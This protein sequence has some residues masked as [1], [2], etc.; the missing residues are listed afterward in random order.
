MNGKLSIKILLLDDD[1]EKAVAFIALLKSTALQIKSC[2]LIT[3]NGKIEK[4]IKILGTNVIFL[5]ICQQ[6]EKSVSIIEKIRSYNNKIPIIILAPKNYQAVAMELLENGAHDYLTDNIKDRLLIE[7]CVT[8]SIKNSST[9]TALIQSNERYELVSKATNDMMWDWDLLN[10]KVFRSE[11]GWNKVFGKQTH[12]ESALVD[13]W[14][15]RTHPNDRAK[16]DELVERILK[17]KT[18]INFELENRMLRNDGMYATVMDRGYVVRNEAGEVIRLIGATQDITKQKKAEEELKKLSKI[19]SETINAVA[20]TNAAGIIQW[21]NESFST[22]TGYSR[23]EIEGVGFIDFFKQLCTTEQTLKYLRTRFNAHKAFAKDVLIQTKTKQKSWLRIQGQPQDNNNEKSFFA[24]M[25]DVSKEK[26]TEEILKASERRFRNMIEKSSEGL[27]LVNE[28]G[29]TLEISL[30]GKKILG[31]KNDED[32]DNSKENLIYKEDVE[33]VDRIFKEVIATPGSVKNAEYRYKMHNGEFIWLESAFHNLLHEPDIHA[34]AIHFRDITSRKYFEQVLRNSEEN[35]RNLFNSNP[36]AIFIWNPQDFSIIEVNEAAIKEY[37]FSKKEFVK[38]GMKAL[39]TKEGI[40][41]LQILGKRITAKQDYK[42]TL[43]LKQ[44]VKNGSIKL[45]EINFRTIDYYGKAACLAIANNITEKT[46][47]EQKL[48]VERRLRQNEITGAVITAQ[49]Q[50]REELGKELHDNINQILATTKLYIEHALKNENMRTVL[51]QSAKGFITSAV[52]EIRSL[53]KS[54]LPPSLGE[55]GLLM[56]LDEL[57]ES[58]E[59]V[60]NFAIITQWNITDEKKLSESLRLTIFRIMQEQLNNIQ[61]HSKAKKVWI[62]LKEKGHFLT[63]TIKDNGAGFDLK[64]N[65]NGVGLKNILSRAYLHNG[66]LTIDTEKGKG[67]ILSVSFKLPV[68][69]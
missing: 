22:I 61:K 28:K 14:W 3:Q 19:A 49:E 20:I 10:N 51:L 13:S 33:R 24:I 66:K 15:D 56:A 29:E 45:M 31:Y 17:D 63:V 16:A 1:A 53:S 5:R 44:Q 43:T 55:V 68:A 69:G 40:R 25:T 62:T 47:L 2:R 54:L 59:P 12:N 11:D 30:S 48:S 32:Y 57:V 46:E 7:K 65:K 27:S 26:E 67:C 42:T 50:E 41:P 23:E 18:L 35:Y 21:I 34:V 39:V 58:I 6:K 36:A 38:L 64:Q 4:A 8:F 52:S 60:S 9:A 37:G